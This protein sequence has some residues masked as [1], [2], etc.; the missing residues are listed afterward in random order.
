MTA[1]RQREQ[2]KQERREA[3]IA[4]AVRVFLERT[5]QGATMDEIARE[6]DV[7]K[8]TLYL[9]FASKEDLFLSV[10][11]QWLDELQAEIEQLRGQPMKSGIEL[12]RAGMK[13]YTRHALKCPGH[14]KVAMSWLNV[15]Y[16]LDDATE[17]YRVYRGAVGKKYE[18]LVGAIERGKKDGS[19]RSHE[20]SE[21][22]AVQLWAAM[23][24]V[25][26]VEQNAEEIGR[27]VAPLGI[28]ATGIAEVFVDNI[29]SAFGESARKPIH[30]HRKSE[31]E[32]HS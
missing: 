16:S 7:S 4:A 8:G 25:I 17:L 14:F 2:K 3:I 29:L 32:P 1:L 26:L 5:V 24:G 20:A 15:P 13:L 31:E 10:A 6:A 9:Y 18:F 28:A 23:L 12:I 19:L 22:I 27:R 11:T 21:K 30:L